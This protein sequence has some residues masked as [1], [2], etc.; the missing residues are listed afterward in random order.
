[1]LLEGGKLVQEEKGRLTVEKFQQFIDILTPSMDDYLYIYDLQGDCY[2]ISPNALERFPLER[3]CFN[4]VVGQLRKLVYPADFEALNA[5]VE[6]IKR[7]EKKFH[8]MQYRWVDQ[9]GKA[10]WINCRGSV[11]LDDFGEP[12]FM[13]GCINE[14]GMS[15]KADNITG[16]LGETSLRAELSKYEKEQ[17]RGYMLRIGVDN[18]KEINENRG[19]EYGNMILRKTAECIEHVLRPGQKLF[20]IVA[21]EF[22]VLDFFEEDYKKSVELYDEI[23][24]EIN[25]FIEKTC[26]DSFFT[27]SAGTLVFSAVEKPSYNNIMKLSE[28]SLNAA[29]NGEKNK[30]Y[31]YNPQDYEK[32]QKKRA[33]LKRLRRAVNEDCR[34]FSAN[35]QPIMHINEHSLFSA[36]TL[37]R[38]ESEETGEVNPTEFIPLLEESGLIIPVGR[39]VMHKAMEACSRIRQYIPNFRISVNV[40]YVQV[41][42]SDILK[43]LVEGEQKY[44]LAPGSIVVELTES[45]FLEA[46]DKF[47]GFCNGLQAHGIPLALDDFGTGYSNFHYL[48]NVKPST[49][50][51]DRSFTSKALQ[52]AYEYNLL[53]HMVDMTHSIELKLC[54]EGIETEEELNRIREINPDYIQGYFFGKPCDFASFFKEYVEVEN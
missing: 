20:R 6:Q 13:V 35:F 19:M 43:E 44:G 45:G 37:L 5:E 28:F 47:M 9:E 16:L 26:Y 3:S 8:N 25:Q 39:F 36:E 11:L 32:F 14:I 41:L 40:S 4:D 33:L 29:K 17:K 22:A 48:Y 18:F 30:I 52:N 49:I 46:D 53:R 2:C 50:K 10:I 38:F 54:I 31:L 1:M 51:I 12:E 42:K 27:V 7:K 23:R 34:G 15:Q 21:D 24:R